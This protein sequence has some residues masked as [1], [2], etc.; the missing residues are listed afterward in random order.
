MSR[1]VVSRERARVAEQWREWCQV[2][3]I[4]IESGI[5]P[6]CRW[7]FA[8]KDRVHCFSCALKIAK[9][10]R[11]KRGY[12]GTRRCGCCRRQGHTAPFCTSPKVLNYQDDKTRRVNAR[13]STK[14]KVA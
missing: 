10:M 12:S 1:D 14:A 4:L 8:R 13:W 11:A 9:R 5:C 6:D 2:R 3:G 7:R